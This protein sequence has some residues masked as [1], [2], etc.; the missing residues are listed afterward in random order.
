MTVGDFK[1]LQPYMWLKVRSKV[2]V[3]KIKLQYRL[4]ILESIIFNGKYCSL[5]KKDFLDEIRN[6][7]TC[8]HETF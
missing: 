1:L 7:F 5:K 3:N 6:S 4:N 8:L 2:Q